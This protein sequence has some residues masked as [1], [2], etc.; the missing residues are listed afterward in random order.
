MIRLKLE[1]PRENFTIAVDVQW[2]S[3]QVH[4][5][6]GPSAAGK[7]SILSVLAGFEDHFRRA[8]LAIDDTV[9]IDSQA[10]PPVFVPAWRRGIGYVQQSARLFPHLSVE[11]NI[12]YGVPGRRVTPWVEELIHYLG[13]KDYRLVKPHH[14]SGGLTQRVA[15][16]RTLAVEPKVLLLDEPFSALDWNVRSTLQDAVIELQSRFDMTILMVT[17]QLTEAQ[18]MAQSIAVM[19]QGRILQ[20]GNLSQVMESPAA[21]EV[22]RLLGYTSL[23][24]VPSGKSFAVHPDRAVLGSFPEIGVPVSGTVLEVF[25]HEGT[26]RIRIQL[27]APWDTVIEARLSARDEVRVDERIVVTFVHPP[28]FDAPRSSK[29]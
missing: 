12:V 20:Q 27:E 1:L 9:L 24:F 10:R 22:A 11:Q 7:S 18:R 2:E 6:F 5:L 4:S 23:L 19:D 13:L 3:G 17:H 21:W 28:Q 8:Y 25:W 16:A 15:L 29:S 14:L 26:S